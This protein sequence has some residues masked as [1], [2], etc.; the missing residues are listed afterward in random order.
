MRFFS[1]TCDLVSSAHL[2]NASHQYA[3]EKK[4]SG[5]GKPF[6]MSPISKGDGTTVATDQ[7]NQD[8][9]MA[10][11]NANSQQYSSMLHT[12]RSLSIGSSNHELASSQ[13]QYT[14]DDMNDNV[15][16]DETE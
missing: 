14:A 12:R 13:S 11:E 2:H 8:N 10:G 6:P 3:G 16:F 15:D 4:S 5:A 9:M 1:Q 7:D